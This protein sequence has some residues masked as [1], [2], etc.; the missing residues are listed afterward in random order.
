[1]ASL[2]AAYTPRRPTETVLYAVVR[3]WLETFLAHARETYEAPVP[4][5]VER[6]LRGYLRCGVF[7]H[8]FIRA[9]CDACGH[10]LLVAF[11]CKARAAC[12]SCTGRRMANVAAHLVDRVLPAVPLR[13]WVLS[14]PF[15]LRRLAAFRADVL[16]ALSRIFHDAVFARYALWAK[17]DGLGAA[18]TGAVCHVQRFGSSINLHV[19]FHSLVLDGVFT[20]DDA[21]R[22]MFHPAP[23]P[24]GDELEAILRRVHARA[25]SW[26]G[27]HGLL[28]VETAAEPEDRR[29]TPLDACASAAMQRGSLRT[30]RDAGEIDAGVRRPLLYTGAPDRFADEAVLG[31]CLCVSAVCLRR[32][33]RA[34]RVRRWADRDS[35]GEDDAIA[36]AD[37]PVLCANG[38]AAVRALA[39][40]GG[41]C[42]TCL[43]ARCCAEAAACSAIDAELGGSSCVDTAVCILVCA[44]DGEGPNCSA[45]CM[46]DAGAS[47]SAAVSA[48]MRLAACTM[49]RCQGAVA[50]PNNCYY[51][52]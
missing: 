8:G 19:H 24:R 47:S 16:S 4:R 26:L 49:S 25:A 40:A 37:A 29:P 48:G 18:P 35:G 38:A 11:S 31:C 23:A 22:P 14:L 7:A 17:R 3:D 42:D 45:S 10:E 28:D 46:D 13:Q 33:P 52:A 34:W 44:V 41:G 20:R 15:E 36:E 2:A 32:D 30:L 12:P 43:D 9:R 6:E 21:G 50:A 1:M 39:G 27:R 51:G 5:Y